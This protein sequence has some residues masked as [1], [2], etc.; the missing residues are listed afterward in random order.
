M[1][2]LRL[3]TVFMSALLVAATVP[4]ATASA[5]IVVGP[6]IG[7]AVILQNQFQ[8]LRNS[9]QREQFQQQQQQYR[10]QDRQIVPQPRTQVPVVKPPCQVLGN[11]ILA[12]CR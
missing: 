3:S 10:A 12:G 4:G 5:Q 8:G 9:F 6:T 7:N 2:S 1:S 11:A